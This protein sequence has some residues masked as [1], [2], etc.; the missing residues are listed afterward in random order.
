MFW[1]RSILELAHRELVAARR[2]APVDAAELVVRQEVA[3]PLELGVA[4]AH[5]GHA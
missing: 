2:R 4:A 3:Q 1:F 5:L